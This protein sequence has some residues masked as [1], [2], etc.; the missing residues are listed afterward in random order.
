MAASDQM[1][2]LACCKINKPDSLFPVADRL[3]TET[4]YR[5]ARPRT[6]DNRSFTLLANNKTKSNRILQKRYTLYIRFHV[7]SGHW[8]SIPFLVEKRVRARDKNRIKSLH[9]A[10]QDRIPPFSFN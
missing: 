10:K 8:N 9:N 4:G 6:V 1:S 7:F 3:S 2:V 5:F